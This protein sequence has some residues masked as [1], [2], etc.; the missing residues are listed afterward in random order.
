MFR[1]FQKEERRILSLTE[2]INNEASYKRVG[3][4]CIPHLRHI[5]ACSP[6]YEFLLII[7]RKRGA[8]TGV[9]LEKSSLCHIPRSLCTGPW[10]Q[11]IGLGGPDGH[12]LLPE[13]ALL[14]VSS[15]RMTLLD[16]NGL[17]LN[18]LTAW[19]ACVPPAGGIHNYLV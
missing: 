4:P 5:Q 18:A 19:G 2:Q 1:R 8:A 3:M 17:E 10:F 12:W 11:T 16:E 15:G 13:E 6:Y 14:M 9:W 7:Y